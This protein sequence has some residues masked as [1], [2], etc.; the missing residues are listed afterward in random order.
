MK[1]RLNKL[2]KELDYFLDHA[3]TEDDCTNEENEMYSD[4]AN[5]KYSIGIV[6]KEK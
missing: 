4:M 1:D 5:L 6:I 3:P 2:L